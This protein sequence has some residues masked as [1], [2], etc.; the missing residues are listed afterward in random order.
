MYL[1][2]YISDKDKF[3]LNPI[4]QAAISGT[5]TGIYQSLI[6]GVPI[7]LVDNHGWTPLHHAVAENRIGVVR[8][9][10]KYQRN[11]NMRNEY[12]W[13]PLHHAAAKGHYN[14]AMLLMICG[15]N[16]TIQDMYGQTPLHIALFG[17]RM[18][19]IDLLIDH[20]A[21]YIT[22]CYGITPFHYAIM[23]KMVKIT[24]RLFCREY[25][26]QPLVGD[27]WT[28]KCI[29]QISAKQLKMEKTFNPDSGMNRRII[30]QSEFAWLPLHC[31]V[32]NGI[33]G[34][35]DF[36]TRHGARDNYID[37]NGNTAFDLVPRNNCTRLLGIKY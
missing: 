9:L 26:W 16:V 13:T 8:F 25:L 32:A 6:N 18:A 15:A 4:H 28:P 1:Q 24:K 12:G 3:G 2:S 29:Y 10:L 30:P 20:G 35:I 36:L 11:I 19:V 33:T 22:D 23:K 7:N 27:I 17:N 5:V 34:L 37:I 21:N 14:I 31:A